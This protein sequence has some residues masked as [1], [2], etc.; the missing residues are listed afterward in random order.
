MRARALLVGVLVVL[1][2]GGC[3][4]GTETPAERAGDLREA[5]DRIEGELLLN[6]V[7]EWRAEYAVAHE[8]SDSKGEDR[9]LREVQRAAHACWDF[10]LEGCS[11]QSKV[12][13][14]VRSLEEEAHQKIPWTIHP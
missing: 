7:E 14:A 1:V 3:G 9:A 5:R 10:G 8:E 6:E 11:E 13:S 2:A 12:E 4:S